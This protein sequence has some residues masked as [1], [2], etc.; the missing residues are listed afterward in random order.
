MTQKFSF[1]NLS[2]WGSKYKD[3]YYRFVIT[4]HVYTVAPPTGNRKESCYGHVDDRGDL[5]WL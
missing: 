3:C 1:M 4:H 5:Y 2:N